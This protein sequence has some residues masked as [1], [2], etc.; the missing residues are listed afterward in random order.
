MMTA[1]PTDKIIAFL[2]HE[3][4]LLV[5]DD[6]LLD[7]TFLPGLEIRGTTIV[8]DGSRLKN[9]GDLLHEAGH[10]ALLPKAVREWHRANG[11]PIPTAMM[12]EI[13]LGA[14][15]WSYAAA[16]HLALPPE[17]VFH[18]DGYH[19]RSEGLLL[20]F[21]L[22]VFPGLTQLES[23]GMAA[24]TKRAV[25]LGVQPFPAMLRWLRD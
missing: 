21:S 1:C 11:L 20:G 23:R 9:C 3:V 8:F 4:G 15:A 16:V 6:A 25:E 14:L 2:R 13:E 7:D 19:G 5:L 10:L 24:G 18:A 22:G 17:L 12:D